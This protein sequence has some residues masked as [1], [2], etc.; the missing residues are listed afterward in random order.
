MKA[1]SMLSRSSASSAASGYGSIQTVSIN[2]SPGPMCGSV[3]GPYSTGSVRFGRRSMWV[4]QVLVA[5]V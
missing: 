3:A 5:I 2:G 1:S 4:R